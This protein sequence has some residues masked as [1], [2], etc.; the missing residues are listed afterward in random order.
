MLSVGLAHNQRRVRFENFTDS[1]NS[2][3]T[4]N[5]VL[6]PK[7]R[8][9]T[10]TVI[11]VNNQSGNSKPKLKRTRTRRPS[12]KK[13]N[14]HKTPTKHIQPNRKRKNNSQTTKRYR[15]TH[16]IERLIEA[17]RRQPKALNTKTQ[18]PNHP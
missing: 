6:I 8:P 10:R 18:T 14:R 1:P 16:K 15:T 4:H 7:W 12:P 11:Q 3:R 17:F 2:Q 13:N 9:K 5:I